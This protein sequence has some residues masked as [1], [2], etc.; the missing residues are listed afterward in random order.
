MTMYHRVA[1]AL[2]AASAALLTVATASAATFTDRAL[3][4]AAVAGQTTIDF[5]G[6]A[7][8]NGFTFLGPA[9]TIG[10]VNFTAVSASNLF[11]VGNDFYYPGNAVFST[12][13]N[14]NGG[15]GVEIDLGG[16]FGAIGFDI[17]SF[18]QSSVTLIDHANGDAATVLTSPSLSNLAFFGFIAEP[19]DN[20][21]SSFSLTIL[22][23][24]VLNIDNLSFAD[25]L[26]VPAPGGLALLLAGLAG[27]GWVRRAK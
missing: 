2:L 10:G 4:E 25:P 22:V 1:A 11:V 3:W 23:T 8:D 17:G 12:Q 24:E 6:L 13:Q 14:V 15:S 19:G 18:N 27:F 5:Q 20:P 26:E 21:F 9:A 7:P 16:A